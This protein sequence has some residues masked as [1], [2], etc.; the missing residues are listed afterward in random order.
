MNPNDLLYARIQRSK[1]YGVGVFAIRNIKRGT[2]IFAGD[3]A[4]I[5][6]LNKSALG[7]LPSSI[8]R[9]YSDFCVRKNKGRT[10]GCPK[11]FNLM[12]VSW[13]LNHSKKPNVRC[14]EKLDFFAARDIKKGK[15]LTVD[16]DTYNEF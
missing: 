2:N 13:Y 6:W 1:R 5:T 11:S 7:G 10:Y 12:T 4:K 15:E 14:D 9:L 16:Y 3:P 8:R